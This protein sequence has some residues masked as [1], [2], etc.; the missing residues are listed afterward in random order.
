V[1]VPIKI[2]TLLFFLI[3]SIVLNGNI[4]KVFIEFILKFIN[5]LEK[6]S[7]I[8]PSILKLDLV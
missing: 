1:N 8:L 7:F 2:H 5:S 6:D 3:L 4:L